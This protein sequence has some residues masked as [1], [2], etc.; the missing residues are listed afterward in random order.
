[1]TISNVIGVNPL[2]TTLLELG[3]VSG[4]VALLLRSAE[5]QPVF[6]D[7]TNDIS[8][9]ICPP[10]N[11]SNASPLKGGCVVCTC[12]KLVSIDITTKHGFVYGC[13]GEAK[14]T[15][16]WMVYENDLMKHH[17]HPFV[18]SRV[19]YM[20]VMVKQ[21]SPSGGWCMRMT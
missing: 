15:K 8:Y 17:L 3:I 11:N 12:V 20:D 6:E 14:F 2:Q 7:F 19:L 5:I 9:I 4:R 16:R 21:N 10:Q 13:H 18:Q 1:M